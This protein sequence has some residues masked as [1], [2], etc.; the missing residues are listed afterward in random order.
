MNTTPIPIAK[1]VEEG[2]VALTTVSPNRYYGVNS[3]HSIGF[4][5]QKEYRYNEYVV[6]CA[7]GITYANY[8]SFSNSSLP[9]LINELIS[10]NF[11]V[12]EFNTAAELFD[13]MSKNSKG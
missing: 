4:I 1:A 3:G 2:S 8:W 6:R 11:K 9:A 7:D 12:Y 13:W 10:C 5:T